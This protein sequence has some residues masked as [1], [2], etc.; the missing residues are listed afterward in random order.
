VLVVTFAAVLAAVIAGVLTCCIGLLLIILPYVGTVVLLPIPVTYRGF[1][2]ALLD[3]IDPGYFPES[4]M[5][6]T[7]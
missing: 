1:T 6:A 3:Q 2:V 7:L 5:A 4:E